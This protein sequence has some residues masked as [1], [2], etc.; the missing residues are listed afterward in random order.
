MTEAFFVDVSICLNQP[1]TAFLNQQRKLNGCIIVFMTIPSPLPD[2]ALSLDV[3]KG[4][5][6]TVAREALTSPK[7]LSHTFTILAT[8]ELRFNLNRLCA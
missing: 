5:K 3:A 2:V 1:T 4:N 6:D 8:V 7:S